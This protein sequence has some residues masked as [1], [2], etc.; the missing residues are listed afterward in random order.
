[1]A[2]WSVQ[3]TTGVA[4]TELAEPY[5]PATAGR[6]DLGAA[7]TLGTVR[8]MDPP[9]LL[10]TGPETFE[11]LLG[12]GHRRALTLAHHTRRGLNLMGVPPLQVA[13]EAVQILLDRG[14]ALHG[15]GELDLGPALGREPSGFEELRVRLA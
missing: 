7:H 1:M 15:D 6:P 13:M 10:Q 3:P 4:R 5:H 14:D 9:T 8:P 11:L 2:R 12:D